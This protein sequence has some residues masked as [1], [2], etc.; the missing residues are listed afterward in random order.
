MVLCCLAL[1]NVRKQ[2]QK[3]HVVADKW[4]LPPPKMY[5]SLPKKGCIW[6]PNFKPGIAGCFFS[7]TYWNRYHEASAKGRRV[8]C[9]A[10]CWRT[11][12]RRRGGRL[13]WGSP[14]CANVC[15]SFIDESQVV[16]KEKKQ[17]VL[18]NLLKMMR[19]VS[20]TWSCLVTWRYFAE[21]LYIH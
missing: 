21:V 17:S 18:E 13:V 15:S 5:K 9:E 20:K 16:K 7:T 6:T 14:C 3:R 2:I 4:H 1:V 19:W 12:A 8:S 11:A 10:S